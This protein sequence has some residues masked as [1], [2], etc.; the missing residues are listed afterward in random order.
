[1]N[2]KSLCYIFLIG[3]SIIG[4]SPA[5][6]R[7]STDFKLTILQMN[8]VYEIS[9]SA[10]G[11][12]GLAA[13][14]GLIDSI[15]KEEKFVLVFHAGDFLNPSL[16]GNLR[17][18]GGEKIAGKQMVEAMNILD[19]DAVAFGNHEF[20]LGEEVLLKRL[21]EMAF[22]MISGNVNHK[23]GDNIEP[24]SLKN[25]SVPK[26][27]IWKFPYLEDSLTVGL[28]S[29]TLPYSQKEWVFY[30]DVMKSASLSNVA[31][32][33]KCD[34]VLF[35][36]HLNRD[37]DQQLA[38]S[39]NNVPLIMGGHDHYHFIDTVGSSYIAKADANAKTIW[40][41]DLVYRSS[42]QKWTV[43]STLINIDERIRPN[44][45]LV[46]L[47]NRWE[48]FARENTAAE[49]FNANRV[50]AEFI[51]VMDATETVIRSEQTKVGEWI[52][53]ALKWSQTNSDVVLFNSGSVRYDDLLPNKITEADILKMLPFGGGVVTAEINGKELREILEIG[54]FENVGT[55]GYFQASEVS[56]V[57]GNWFIGNNPIQ[58]DSVYNMVSTSYLSMGKEKGLSKLGNYTWY[59]PSKVQ[60]E[61]LENDIRKI[62]IAYSQSGVFNSRN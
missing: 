40:R 25:Q 56:K 17:D 59:A 31:L 55:G 20:D 2:L 34:L 37:E 46:D 18:S 51:D 52:C 10:D 29:V 24:F 43:S 16:I 42:S 6:N 39:L 9:A 36:T 12:G 8:D 5:Q 15:R 48:E 61:G 33:E 54:L 32:Q 60:E 44:E 49:G 11:K 50:V 53:D 41:H 35:L 30:D 21:D 58:D 13:V 1:M 45:T 3:V 27:L 38:A 47:V 7:D 57:N 62:L 14:G 26:T 28:G 19:L 4:C 23:V 22:S